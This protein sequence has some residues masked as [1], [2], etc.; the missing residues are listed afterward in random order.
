MWWQ[1]LIMGFWNGLTAWVVFIVH[2]FGGWP[3][4][5]FYDT[6]RSGNWY[7]FAFLLGAGSPILGALGSNRGRVIYR[8]RKIPKNTDLRMQG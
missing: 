2:V 4:Y 1:D 3:E 7:D 6:A 8:D 5:P